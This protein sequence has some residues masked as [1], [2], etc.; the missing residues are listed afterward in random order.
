MVPD[1]RCSHFR[2]EMPSKADFNLLNFH[3]A[4]ILFFYGTKTDEMEE[5]YQLPLA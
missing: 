4:V 1:E 5:K 3:D 2:S